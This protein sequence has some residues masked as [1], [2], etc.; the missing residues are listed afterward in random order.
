MLVSK[1]WDA[2]SMAGFDGTNSSSSKDEGRGELGDMAVVVV[3]SNE[4]K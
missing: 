1:L 3:V 4:L 2:E